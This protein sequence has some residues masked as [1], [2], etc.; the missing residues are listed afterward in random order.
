MSFYGQAIITLIDASGLWVEADYVTSTG[1][2]PDEIK[3]S[4]AIEVVQPT[5]RYGYTDQDGAAVQLGVLE[6]TDPMWQYY[7][8]GTWYLPYQQEYNGWREGNP[9]YL[10]DAAS[11]QMD[12]FSTN[13]EPGRLEGYVVLTDAGVELF[14]QLDL[15]YFNTYK[16]FNYLLG[17]TL[18]KDFAKGDVQSWKLKETQG[19]RFVSRDSTQPIVELTDL[20]VFDDAAAR[21]YDYTVRYTVK[22]R[23]GNV[24]EENAQNWFTV[25]AGEYIVEIWLESKRYEVDGTSYTY[26]LTVCNEEDVFEFVLEDVTRGK[27]VDESYVGYV[28]DRANHYIDVSAWYAPGEVG[29]YTF[30]GLKF[31]DL[32]SGKDMRIDSVL[33]SFTGEEG[34]FVPLDQL[35]FSADKPGDYYLYYRVEGT[36]MSGDEEIPMLAED[37][38]AICISPIDLSQTFGNLDLDLLWYGEYVEVYNGSPRKLSNV[39][40]TD[41][42]RTIGDW[43][44][45]PTLDDLKVQF[46]IQGDGGNPI[47]YEDTIYG[48]IGFEVR[49]RRVWLEWDEYHQPMYLERSYGFNYRVDSY[50]S[51]GNSGPSYVMDND[52]EEVVIWDWAY[53]WEGN[54][55]DVNGEEIPQYVNGDVTD[56]DD[57]L[58]IIP[59]LLDGYQDPYGWSLR[60]AF[61]EIGLTRLDW[62]VMV[63]FYDYNSLSAG[64][65]ASLESRTLSGTMEIT[66]TTTSEDLKLILE[67]LNRDGAYVVGVHYAGYNAQGT[68]LFSLT[69]YAT[70][71]TPT[72]LEIGTRDKEEVYYDGNEHGVTF[73]GLRENDVIEWTYQEVD[74]ETG[75]PVGGQHT[76]T[77]LVIGFD[78]E[79]G[80]PVGVDYDPDDP[81]WWPDPSLPVNCVSPMF[82]GDMLY[83]SVYEVSYTIRREPVRVLEPTRAMALARSS[84]FQSYEGDYEEWLPRYVQPIYRPYQSQ[85]QLTIKA[86]AKMD[87]VGVTSDGYEGLEDGDRHGIVISGLN[88]DAQQQ[89]SDQVLLT[90]RDEMG[91]AIAGLENVTL[92]DLGASVRADGTVYVPLLASTNGETY[93]VSYTVTRG[94]VFRPLTA[95][96]T[97][98]LLSGDTVVGVD[99]TVTYDAKPHTITLDN[100][101][102]DGAGMG[103][104]TVVNWWTSVDGTKTQVMPTFTEEGVYTIYFEAQR[105]L[106]GEQGTYVQTYVGSAVLEILPFNVTASGWTGVYDGK[107][108]GVALN[109]IDWTNDTVQYAIGSGAF[110]TAASADQLPRFTDAGDYAIVLRVTH[111]GATLDLPV[112]VT[113]LPKRITGVVADGVRAYADGKDYA[114]SV[115][116]IPEGAE[117]VYLVDGAETSVNPTYRDVGSYTVP[118]VI[119]GANYEDYHGQATINLLE[120]VGIVADGYEGVWD[121]QKHGIAVHGAGSEDKVYYRIGEN[122][123]ETL[124]NPEFADI[125]SYDVY[126]R[127][128]RYLDGKLAYTESGMQTVNILPLNEPKLIITGYSGTYDGEYHDGVNI[129]G[130]LQGMT[131]RYFDNDL[132][133]WLTEKP[134]FKDAGT[135]SITVSVVNALGDAIALEQI[136]VSIARRPLS[137]NLDGL[138]LDGLTKVEDGTAQIDGVQG[139]LGVDGVLAGDQ[140]NLGYEDFTAYLL[141]NELGASVPAAV[142][143]DGLQ[144]DNP[145]YMLPE[146][147]IFTFRVRYIPDLPD[148]LPIPDA[149]YDGTAHE[150]DISLEGLEPGE[151]Y[152]IERYENNVNAGTATIHVIGLGALAGHSASYTFRIHPAALPQPDALADQIYVGIAIE[153]QVNIPGL[154]HGKDFAVR[155]ADNV[156]PGIATAI[157]TG[158]GN[159]AGS[160]TLH[161]EIL[162]QSEETPLPEPGKK[163]E[164]SKPASIVTDENWKPMPYERKDVWMQIEGRNG[165]ARVLVIEALPVLDANG[166]AVMQADGTPL[167]ALRNLHLSAAMLARLESTGYEYVLFRVGEAVLLIELAQLERANH[168][169]TLEPILSGAGTQ[170]E[171][172]RRSGD[173]RAWVCR[174]GERIP[175]AE[176]QIWL[177][178]AEEEMD[179]PHEARDAIGIFVTDTDDVQLNEG[180]RL[181]AHEAGW[182][183]GDGWDGTYWV[184]QAPA[185]MDDELTFAAVSGENE[186]T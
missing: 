48:E 160:Y 122:G 4:H 174:N 128:E 186:P 56:M 94:L 183:D 151:D 50:L 146:D 14:E 20:V 76:A 34:T 9:V 143:F 135:H 25:G 117:I 90:V 54:Y 166:R 87:I 31:S 42:I 124:V 104:A 30:Y 95:T 18:W 182:I 27:T 116:G 171:L 133:V 134:R 107:S 70:F 21:L 138:N 40:T 152:R 175:F 98:R 23:D 58:V 164:H 145:N 136:H 180:I 61:E 129:S 22:D 154:I 144:I 155:Y 10:T 114:I 81:Y 19:V 127:V 24:L 91:V 158:I 2:Y 45:T 83:D 131:V 93:E 78:P 170:S 3:Y 121:G 89:V 79:T 5:L 28:Y 177:G 173:W 7:F 168:I 163:P 105:S 66:A 132:G 15:S 148:S 86:T 109:D 113:I 162:E 47:Y 39:V 52:W 139:S 112:N 64:K 172:E 101:E 103:D 153:P 13:G 32:T 149:T 71:C 59:Y 41:G 37:M 63:E 49:V 159:Y 118:F 69:D 141:S 137:W 8:Q 150:P 68:G 53:S 51:E 65:T 111:G 38:L 35:D 184:T 33:V 77:Y 26:E 60:S 126:F 185:C 44:Y 156:L 125:G 57:A 85:T 165:E 119:R 6:Y 82:L 16:R 97:L 75:L 176:A 74:A 73:D 108:H 29:D 181:F 123:A 142:R 147:A 67:N 157:V 62:E 178:F 88:V 80:L 84:A 43:N 179:A 130:D 99:N 102:G 110:A 140:V 11:A 169:F 72:Q 1:P 55:A 115:S 96:A 120:L 161:F 12:P 100:L 167:Y 17:V 36:A 46:E 92:A 106:T